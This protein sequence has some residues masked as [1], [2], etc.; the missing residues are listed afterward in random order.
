[1]KP[2]PRE[3]LD[4]RDIHADGT[5]TLPLKKKGVYSRIK[6]GGLKKKTSD[7]SRGLFMKFTKIM[8]L[9]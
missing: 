8:L 2:M 9:L 3:G 7:G 1:M 4:S 6:S 5:M